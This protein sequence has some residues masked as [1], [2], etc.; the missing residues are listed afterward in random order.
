LRGVLTPAAFDSRQRIVAMTELTRK[1]GGGR[2]AARLMTDVSLLEAWSHWRAG[3]PTSDLE[4]W[5]HSMLF[6]GR[7]GKLLQFVGALTVIAELIG[8]DRLQRLGA[9][10]HGPDTPVTRAQRR[11]RARIQSVK[12]KLS[13]L[14]VGAIALLF[15]L[16]IVVGNSLYAV[17]AWRAFR[18]QGFK[19]LISQEWVL[20]L[21]QPFW[22]K[23]ALVYGSPVLIPLTAWLC[24]YALPML[25]LAFLN[26]LGRVA[27]QCVIRPVAWTLDRSALGALVKVM[28]LVLLLVGTHFDLLAS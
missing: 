12:D 22:P 15:G 18:E 6:W 11:L 5:G 16:A 26:V 13:S 28:S 25:G 17:L 10:W 21:I 24:V 4:L 1:A 20:E 9:S 7:L 23:G 8:V 27:D 3:Q 19:A 2:L 14:T